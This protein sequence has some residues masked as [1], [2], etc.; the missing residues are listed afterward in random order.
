M[1]KFLLVFAVLVLCGCYDEAPK[2]RNRTN[3][4]FIET[5]EGHDYIIYDGY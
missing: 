5:V 3:T 4:L 2:K 1:K